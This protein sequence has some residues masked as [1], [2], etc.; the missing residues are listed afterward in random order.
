MTPEDWIALELLTRTERRGDILGPFELSD[1]TG[2]PS[3]STAVYVALDI[4]GRV[5]Y[6]GSVC[7]PTGPGLRRRIGE[8][9]RDLQ[10]A[11]RWRALWVIMLPPEV[12][13][14]R[15]RALE[16]AVGACLA[17]RHNRALPRPLPRW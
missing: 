3:V 15:I 9:R 6:V 10:R 2:L 4:H 14:P 17:P 8:H 12:P 16:G 11:R 7:R 1:P 13:R 5:D